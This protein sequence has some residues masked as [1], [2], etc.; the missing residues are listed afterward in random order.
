[1]N[2]QTPED[3]NDLAADLALCVA[4]ILDHPACPESL[5]DA[6]NEAASALIDQL[7]GGNIALEL[8]ALASAAIAKDGDV[9]RLDLASPDLLMVDRDRSDLAE[10][11][12]ARRQSPATIA[13]NGDV[14][15]GGLHRHI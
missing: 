3:F 4:D 7:S 5:R 12:D 10:S 8:R 9:T 1:M 11:E 2:K 15:G 13:A 6:L 14:A